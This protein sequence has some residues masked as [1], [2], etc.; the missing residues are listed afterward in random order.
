MRLPEMRLVIA[1]LEDALL[2]VT[3]NGGRRRGREFVEACEW[4]RDERRD[5]PF[6]F[7][8]V[9][10]LL[11]LEATAVRQRIRLGKPSH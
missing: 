11:G 5:S 3:R 4:F 7:R 10:D 2:C 9:C 8:N 1:I 6:A